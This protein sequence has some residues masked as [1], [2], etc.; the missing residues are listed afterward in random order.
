MHIV[1]MDGATLGPGLDLSGLEALGDVTVYDATAPEEAAERLRDADITLVNK[2]RLG[3]GNLTGNT[4]LKLICEAATGYDNIDVSWCGEHGIAVCNVPG[5]STDCVAQL[6]AAMAL[7]LTNHLGT[8]TRAVGSGAYSRG[9]SANIL[10]PVYHELRGQTWGV[11][12]YGRIGKRVAEIASVLGCRVVC[13]RKHPQPGDP[14]VPLEELCRVSDILSVH[15][16]LNDG[17]RGLFSRELIGLCKP[18]C[19]FINV[20]RGAVADEAALAEALT[21]GRLGGLGID[22]YSAEPFP[23][24]HPFYPLREREDVCFTPHMAWGGLE[25]RQRCLREIEEN[26]SAFLRG[27]RRN[28]VDVS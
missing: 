19:L 11:A 3:P 4:R 13:W 2:L 8:Y 24:T 17:T 28:R 16:P 12:G 6:T 20:A 18:T 15:L 5:Y 25:T 27:E 14:C 1:I 7:Y 22:V 26:I 21:A 23:E 10:S 9:G